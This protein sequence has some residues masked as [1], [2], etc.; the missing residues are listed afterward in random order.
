MIGILRSTISWHNFKEKS[1]GQIATLLMLILVTVLI[2]ILV[3]A[4]LGQISINTTVLANAADAAALSLASQLSTRSR[5]MSDALKNACNNRTQCCRKCGW[6]GIILAI[7]FV[8]IAIII[9]IITWGYTY[10]LIPIA[11]AAGAAGYGMGN[12]IIHGSGSEVSSYLIA[13]LLGG[14]I[15]AALSTLLMDKE[16]REVVLEGMIQGFVIG[17]AIGAAVV[18]LG[19]ALC[20]AVGAGGGTAGTGGATIVQGSV[21]TVVPAGGAV[22]G[23]VTLISGSVIT[24]AG[25]TIVAGGIAATAIA[26]LGIGLSVAGPVY[27][28]YIYAKD[29]AA[30][31]QA[32]ADALNG[33]PEYDR[34]REGVFLSVLPQVIDDPTTVQ[35]INDMDGD[36]DVDEK[37]PRF[38]ALWNDRMGEY[39]A[40]VSNLESITTTFVNVDL[41]S[42]ESYL[43]SA[44]PVST[45][46]SLGSAST[47]FSRQEIEGSDGK[48]IDLMRRL[49]QNDAWITSTYGPTYS[50][51]PAMSLI[52]EPGP[53]LAQVQCYEGGGC[54]VPPGS[55]E[56]DD[57]ISK[58]S[59]FLG[60]AGDL[61]QQSIPILATTW[62]TW[63]PELYDTSTIVDYYDVLGETVNGDL[64]SYP[65]I[66]G[67]QYWKDN[68]LEGK[69]QDYKDLAD[70]RLPRP[71]SSSDLPYPVNNSEFLG[72]QNSLNT[73]ISQIN[74]F[75]NA[76]QAY[77][78]AM[79]IAYSSLTI[80]TLSG[81]NPVVY[82]WGDSR[83]SHSITV[84]VG[85][86]KLA[87]MEK[88]GSCK[89]F[90]G[91]QCLKLKDYTD[92]GRCW[93]KITRQ[94]PTN[95][96]VGSGR[97][98]FGWWNPFS[99]GTITKT[100]RVYYSYDRVGL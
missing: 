76:S 95:Q 50:L 28:Y 91:K 88:S 99:S 32:A 20:P 84:E 82:S 86:F 31:F 45:S 60:W 79:T 40:L 19:Q 26:A 67:I 12:V 27:N 52:Y 1:S 66:Y 6:L 48:V 85:P 62:Q 54:T 73:L 71:F 9:T 58:M 65:L 63:V 46:T 35:D 8:I 10:W 51:G 14:V 69:R 42:F 22:P 4:N 3:T 39:S 11:A 93:V 94:D 30:A 68:V 21:T 47:E 77:Y 92:A 87:R 17:A 15:G 33:L 72:V 100:G 97:V 23:G 29:I 5:V 81:A 25:G 41:A 56:V 49:Y 89:K 44:F 70:G 61:K 24:A 43:R 38:F 34:Y 53:T 78:N 36:G 98:G 37:I 57:V 90:V 83:G 18:T 59:E 74:T 16:T 80:A 96:P 2:F 75:R 7:I 55:D 64:T 13:H